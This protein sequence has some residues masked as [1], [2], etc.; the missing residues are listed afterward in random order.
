MAD[1]SPLVQERRAKAA[2]LRGSGREPF[3]WSFPGRVPTSEVVAAGRTM[4]PGEADPARRFRVAGRVRAI[5]GHGRSAFLDLDDLAGTLQLYARVDELGE[6]G[7]ARLLQ[8]IDPGDLVG[9][10]GVPIVTRRGEPS[11]RVSAIE[12]L[13][14]ALNPPPEKYHGLQDP[15]ERIRRRYVDLLASP[16]SRAR[17]RARSLVTRALRRHLDGLGFLEVETPTLVPVASGAAAQPFTTHS[18]YLDRELQ[19]RIALELPLK[20]LLVGGL[21]RVYEVGHV[22]RNEDLDSTHSPEFTM[23]ELYWAYADY[24]DMRGLVEGLYAGLAKEVAELFPDLPAAREAPDRFRPPFAAIDFVEELERRSGISGL[25]EKS[26]EELRALARA[27]GATVPDDSPSGKFLDKLFEH[28]VEPSLDR[29]TF[30]FDFPAST[31]PLAKRHRSR[32]GRV[33]R[34]E[35]F[36]RGLELGNAYTEL[37]DPDEQERRFAEQLSSRGEDHYAY[38]SDFVE[39]LRYGMPPATGLGIGIDRMFM[40]LTGTPSIKDVIL[41]LPTRERSTG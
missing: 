14:K 21:E 37:N 5:R 25:L 16:E 24:T 22:F 11:L 18:N 12:I 30:V 34:F 35:L 38:D 2:R 40:A 28:Y 27:G 36:A 6:E 39:A 13:A 23:M 26:R 31:T 19:L 15:E 20:R 17:F 33:E 41:F 1:E 4:P 9:A 32:P 10:D 7:L 29:P 3:P 8:D